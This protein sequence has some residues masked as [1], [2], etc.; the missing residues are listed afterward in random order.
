MIMAQMLREKCISSSVYFSHWSNIP[1]A[2]LLIITLIPWGDV[3]AAETPDSDYVFDPTLFKGGNFDQSSL[4]R[5]RLSGAVSPGEYKV[6]VPGMDF[7]CWAKN[8]RFNKTG[9]K[10]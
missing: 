10:T 9:A 2:L 8:K 7:N 1:R 4:E 6:D 5:L 3:V